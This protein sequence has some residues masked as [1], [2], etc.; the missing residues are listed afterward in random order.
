MRALFR[1]ALAANSFLVANP[2]DGEVLSFFQQ[3]LTESIGAA[4]LPAEQQ[5]SIGYAFRGILSGNFSTANPSDANVV[6]F[7]AQ[8]TTDA[9]GAA[10]LNTDRY[11][12]LKAT[13][14]NVVSLN[15][16]GTVNPSLA[17]LLGYFGSYSS[18]WVEIGTRSTIPDASFSSPATN[19]NS[20][21][22]VF[23]RGGPIS[24]LKVSWANWQTS[25]ALAPVGSGGTMTMTAAVE[26]PVGTLLGVF[27]F[28]GA[29]QGVAADGDTLDSDPLY[30]GTPIPDGAK[31]MI[32]RCV[33][34]SGNALY[35]FRP[36]KSLPAG[37]ASIAV[38]GNNDRTQSGVFADDG[39]NYNLPPARVMGLAASPVDRL[40]IGDSREQ[41]YSETA[42]QQDAAGDSGMSARRIGATR[43][44]FRVGGSGNTIANLVANPT[45]HFALIAKANPSKIIISMGFN[46]FN[47]GVGTDAGVR[48]LTISLIALLRSAAPNAL[49]YLATIPPKTTSTDGWIT[50]AN[51]TLSSFNTELQNHNAWRR[52][53][54]ANGVADGFLEIA[55][56]MES[57][58]NSGKWGFSAG[59]LAWTDDGVHPYKLGSQQIAYP[60]P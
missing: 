50:T 25:N 19:S 29:T 1:S 36:L 32:T 31:I 26:Y 58:A 21:N 8:L 14:R 43:A 41:G 60:I 53:A 48:A 35:T 27:K 20:R 9:T 17:D 42:A 55:N 2:S 16:P 18:T 13:L 39:F 23:V 45:K 37:D 15:Y 10:A 5:A 51:Q 22:A 47:A 40:I 6:D 44:Y 49:I 57:S 34:F 56:Y 59:P 4:A 3:L 33:R 24:A 38:D 30:L 52:N 28:G 12:T 11:K 7:W 46:D 54:V